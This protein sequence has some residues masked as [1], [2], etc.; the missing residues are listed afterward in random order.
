MMWEVNTLTLVDFLEVGDIINH[1]GTVY[2]V[3]SI[4]YREYHNEMWE[5]VG[6]DD[7]WEEPATFFIPDG[8]MVELMIWKEEE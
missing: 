1:E 2:T 6:V 5:I 3:D 4:D 7:E 8:H